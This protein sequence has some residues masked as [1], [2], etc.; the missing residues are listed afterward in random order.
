[1]YSLQLMF[2]VS[3]KY[4]KKNSKSDTFWFLFSCLQIYVHCHIRI[5]ATIV[6][7]KHCFQFT[8]FYLE[9]SLF[10]TWNRLIQDPLINKM[11][12]GKLQ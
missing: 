7:R 6:C 4:T 12:K 5:K 8:D 11:Y 2:K 1:M 10:H 3:L 9:T